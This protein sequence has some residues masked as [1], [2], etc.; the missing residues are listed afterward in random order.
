VHFQGVVSGNLPREVLET[1][2]GQLAFCIRCIPMHTHQS[3]G[4]V[5]PLSIA[6]ELHT[7]VN[8]ILLG[9]LQRLHPPQIWRFRIARFNEST[10]DL[11]TNFYRLNF[12]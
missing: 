9:C 4:S 8:G 5:F 11:Q 7:E 6:R 12:V 3:Y 2:A 1:E 10:N